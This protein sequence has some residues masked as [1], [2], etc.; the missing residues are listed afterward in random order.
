MKKL[1]KI[2]AQIFCTKI[3]LFFV[4][5]LL[6]FGFGLLSNYYDWAWLA[7]YISLI[8]PLALVIILIIYATII[9]PLRE[10]KET[11]KLRDE[12]K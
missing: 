9:N 7:M 5:I 10:R 6:A 11:K 8:Y 1:F 12:N 3:G 2:L 4:T